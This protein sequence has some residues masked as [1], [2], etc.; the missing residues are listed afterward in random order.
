MS[1]REAVKIT[2]PAEL[3]AWVDSERASSGMTRSQYIEGLLRGIPDLPA[4]PPRESGASKPS[5][6]SSRKSRADSIALL[7]HLTTN[8]NLR[9]R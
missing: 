7:R 1:Q 2:L 3:V 5:K 8:L 6:A 4:K 9:M